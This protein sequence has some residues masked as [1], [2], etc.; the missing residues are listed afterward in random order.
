MYK[1][2]VFVLYLCNK[3]IL[4]IAINDICASLGGPSVREYMK[5]FGK[6]KEKVNKKLGDFRKQFGKTRN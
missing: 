5:K 4:S 6:L 2:S 3:I 1:L